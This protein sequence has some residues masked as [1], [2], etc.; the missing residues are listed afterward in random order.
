MP[1]RLSPSPDTFTI[2][3]TESTLTHDDTV[4]QLAGLGPHGEVAALRAHRAD[5]TRY[6]QASL[7]ALLDADVDDLPLAERLAAAAYAA[8]LTRGEPLARL[9]RERLA[10]LGAD[11]TQAAAVLTTLIDADVAHVDAN[12]ALRGA[13]ARIAAILAHTRAVTATP[14]Q[15]AENGPAALATLQRAGLST[16]AIVVLSQLI[17]FVAYQAR[18]VAALRVLEGSV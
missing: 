14:A 5:A 8:T 13:P 15:T 2:M 11:G 7:D 3:S 1:M 10:T 16:R 6:T 4:A 17:A 18:V 9:Y 12:D